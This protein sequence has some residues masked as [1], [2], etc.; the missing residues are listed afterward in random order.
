[1]TSQVLS[2]AGYSVFKAGTANA[3]L[4]AF[5]RYGKKLQLVI[6]DLV[7][8]GKDGRALAAEMKAI[9]PDLKVLLTSGYPETALN[10]SAIEGIEY[11][12]KPF[13]ADSLLNK[14]HQVLR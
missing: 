7:L 5:R 4:T 1:V 14:V 13:S 12:S 6:T 10:T 3:A 11:L 9:R 2:L 8:P